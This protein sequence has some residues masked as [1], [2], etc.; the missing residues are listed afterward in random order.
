MSI[1]NTHAFKLVTLTLKKH[2]GNNLSYHNSTHVSR[3]VERALYLFDTSNQKYMEDYKAALIIAALGHDIIYIPGSTYNEAASADY[4][5]YLMSKFSEFNESPVKDKVK[6]LILGTAISEHLSE[7]EQTPLQNILLDAD[8]VAMADPYPDFERTQLS[9]LA[10][11]LGDSSSIPKMKDFL[12]LFLNKKKIYR[13]NQ[14]DSF[15]SSARVNIEMFLNFN[16]AH[17]AQKLQNY[18]IEAAINAD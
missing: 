15:E 9:I 13:C 14:I 7:A 10:E 4:V 5:V 3:V 16:N 12:Q 11:N 1:M 17:L 6:N 18:Y 8:L 2:M